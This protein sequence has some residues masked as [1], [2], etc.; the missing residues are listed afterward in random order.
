MKTV[1]KL[2][3]SMPVKTIQFPNPVTYVKE[4]L[5]EVSITV[6]IFQHFDSTEDFIKLPEELKDV[7]Y[8]VGVISYLFVS[9]ILGRKDV[10]VILNVDGDLGVPKVILC[11][12]KRLSPEEE[13]DLLKRV[14]DVLWW[15]SSYDE[16]VL[17]VPVIIDWR[18]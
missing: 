17:D 3:P 18:R 5:K 15:Y 6:E 10:R 2:F 16:R 12:H 9:K 1:S 11:F 7:G 8:K 14:S 4:F 13:I